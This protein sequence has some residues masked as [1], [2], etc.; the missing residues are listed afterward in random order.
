MAPTAKSV[1]AGANHALQVLL[2]VA[3]VDG[4]SVRQPRLA[5]VGPAE[6]VVNMTRDHCCRPD[7]ACLNWAGHLGEQPDSVPGAW[8]NPLTNTT[9]LISATAWGHYATVGPSLSD[10]RTRVCE[11]PVYVSVNKTTPQSYANNQW[12]Q[13]ARVFPNGTGVALVHNEFHGD[14]ICR[15][16]DCKYCSRNHSV[17]GIECETWTVDLGMTYDGGATWTATHSPVLTVPKRFQKD[18]ARSGYGALGSLIFNS[19][20]GWYY[21]HV[22][23]AKS[24]GAPENRTGFCTFRTR[25]PA[26][27]STYRGW[28]GTAW[29]TVWVDPYDVPQPIPAADLYKYECALATHSDRSAHPSPR[30]FAPDTAAAH[31]EWPSAVMF[32]WPEEMSNVMSYSFPE[33]GT[34]APFTAWGNASFLDVRDWL[35]PHQFATPLMYPTVLD[36]DSPFSSGV[37]PSDEDAATALSYG[38]VGNNSMHLYFVVD[39]KYIARLPVAWFLAGAPTPTGPYPAPPDNTP[40]CPV[41]RVTGAGMA[42]ANGDYRIEPDLHNDHHAYAKDGVHRVL[43][44]GVAPL[45]CRWTITQDGQALYEATA[46]SGTKLAP[47]PEGWAVVP[48]GRGVAPYPVVKCTD[49]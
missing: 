35:D 1:L 42:G 45:P 30:V 43:C 2:V 5:A 16:G 17:P 22:A 46:M 44:S 28:N 47:P 39:R 31:P 33:E 8:H 37:D 38:F 12:L 7:G 18:Q 3:V 36:H 29:A 11:T 27:P 21:G 48:S 15:R 34:G 49:L 41:V 20:D 25:W 9:Y 19:E 23:K 26:D 10:L 4:S 14:Q 40:G 6:I 24:A 32:G 13:A